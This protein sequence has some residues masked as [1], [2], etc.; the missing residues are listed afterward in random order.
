MLSLGLIHN[1][2]FFKSIYANTVLGKGSGN[3]L[4]LDSQSVTLDDFRKLFDAKVPKLEKVWAAIRK[5]VDERA[6]I[7]VNAKRYNEMKEGSVFKEIL[8]EKIE[9][10]S[11]SQEGRESPS[12]EMR[13]KVQELSKAYT[14]RFLAKVIN[15]SKDLREVQKIIDFDLKE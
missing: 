15:N 7:R 4:S 5:E 9:K 2:T 12:W 1:G 13:G 3:H 10:M 6:R 11:P 8:L 14:T